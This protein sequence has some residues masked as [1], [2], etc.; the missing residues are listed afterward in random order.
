MKI[1][2]K[3]FTLIAFIIAFISYV[4]ISFASNQKNILTLQ[5]ETKELN[6]LYLEAIKN[7]GSLTVWAGGD[8]P[9]QADWLKKKFNTRFPEIKLN[10]I[11]D[12]SKFHDIRIDKNLLSGNEIP[13]VTMLQTTFDFDKWKKEGVL[14]YYKPIGFEQQK[15]GYAD[16]DGAYIT[17]YNNAFIPNVSKKADF[18]PQKGYLNFLDSQ[19]KN[20]LVLIYPSDD[21]AVAYVYAKIEEKYG[22]DFLKKLANQ[23]P[24]FYRGTAVPAFIIQYDTTNKYY[25]NIT[26]YMNDD[27][28]S[29]A[30]YFIPE[31]DPFIVWNQRAAIFKKSK[32][33]TAAKLFLSY[34]SSYEFQSSYSGW[35][36]RIDVNEYGNLPPLE[37]LTN[38][39]TSDFTQWMA[40]RENV[41]KYRIHLETIFGKAL[42]ETPM[43]DINLIK[44][45]KLN[46]SDIK[47]LPEPSEPI[48]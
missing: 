21:D 10:L 36:T 6:D 32:N 24:K 8:A 3:Y 38:T 19:F 40:N 1:K 33:K 15:W 42:G 2:Y 20:K 22:I 29:E 34:L 28:K 23:N 4:P 41:R 18:D 12:L 44:I 5:K 26:G 11:V 13:D 14:F 9:N 7:G 17:A 16:K 45:L 46:A 37:T 48:Y 47:N 25:G 39:S 35:R 27:L 31:N 43:M 30:V